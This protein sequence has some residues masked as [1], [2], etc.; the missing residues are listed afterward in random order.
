MS[1]T[2]RE[3]FHPAAEW[4]ETDGLGGFA[5]TIDW[6]F[7]VFFSKDFVQYLHERAR[8]MSRS[9]IQPPPPSSAPCDRAAATQKQP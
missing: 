8:T 2:K 4:L 3:P 7:D 5:S 6:A 9:E 1:S